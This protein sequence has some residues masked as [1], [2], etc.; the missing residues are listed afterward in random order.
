MLQ[1]YFELRLP[2]STPR[3]VVPVLQSVALGYGIF[4]CAT[5]IHDNFHHPQD[6]LG[7]VILGI[8]TSWVTVRSRGVMMLM[9]SVW[10]CL[11]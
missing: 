2:S 6:V 5:R 10:S 9:P 1:L 8:V 3:L 11:Q 7:G 4:V